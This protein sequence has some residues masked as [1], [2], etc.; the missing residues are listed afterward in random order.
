[1]FWRMEKYAGHVYYHCFYLLCIG[2][3][4]G[5]MGTTGLNGYY[6]YAPFYISRT[7]YQNCTE[8]N[9]LFIVIYY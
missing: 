2:G 3:D 9:V 1:M 5:K 7:K 6:R 8:E 4:L